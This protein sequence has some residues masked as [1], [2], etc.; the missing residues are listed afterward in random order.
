MKFPF[1]KTIGF[2]LFAA[3]VAPVSSQEPPVDEPIRPK[4]GPQKVNGIAATVNGDLITLNELMIK[5]APLQSVLM[6]R[7]PRRGQAY[8]SQLAELK[9]SILDELVDRT[10][11]FT[12]FKDRV[13]EFPD[14][15]IEEEVQRIV[16]TVYQGDEELFKQYLKKTN[17]T[18]DQFKEQQRKE[19]LVQIVRSQHYG[20]V[21]VPKESELRKEYERW[22][23]T[24]RDRNKDVATYR[25]IYLRKDRGGGPLAQLSLTEK[26]ADQI[27][28]GGDFEE[29][30]KRYSQDSHAKDA[31]LWEDC[32]RP[33]MSMEFAHVI[34][35]LEGNEVLG[36]L[37]DQNGFN[38]I[39]VIKRTLGPAKPFEEAREELQRLVISGKKKA[40]F[41]KW[42]KKERSRAIIKKML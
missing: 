28:A 24:N 42:M 23:I 27:K 13:R 29:L 1:F 21:A 11:I 26:L 22:K 34:F 8:Q 9:A 41:D 37:E 18:R 14:Q 7:F 4:Q 20:D 17:L 40:N 39:Q 16:Q 30:A 2:A 36:P 6:S 32:E 33:D 25:R 35:E 3:M 38:I 10:I 19:L 15:Q 12:N 5:V 31:G